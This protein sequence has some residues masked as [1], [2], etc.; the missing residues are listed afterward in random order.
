MTLRPLMITA[1]ALTF[2]PTAGAAFDGCDVRPRAYDRDVAPALTGAWTAANGA[3][4]MWMFQGGMQ[5]MAMPMP[6]EAPAAMQI[7]L[8]DGN[9]VMSGGEFPEVP[10]T[11]STLDE[12]PDA[13]M[14]VPE[15]LVGQLPAPGPD[16]ASLATPLGCDA[17]DLP[18]L[19]M[20]GDVPMEETGGTV[21]FQTVL[22]AVDENTLSGRMTFSGTMQGM[23]IFADR[24]VTLTR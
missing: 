6:T 10:A 3:G 16:A 24:A 22:F 4:N 15:S 21:V 11:L 23:T 7:D 13:G 8:V 14:T 12:V 20:M 9:L 18:V 5:M 1:M 2:L 17:G 19:S